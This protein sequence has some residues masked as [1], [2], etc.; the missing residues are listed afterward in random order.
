MGTMLRTAWCRRRA[1]AGCFGIL[2]AEYAGDV[3]VFVCVQKMKNHAFMGITLCLKNLFGLTVQEPYGRARQY[4]HHIIRMPYL[5]ADLGQIID[6]ALCIVDLAWSGYRG[7]NG[8]GSLARR[9][10]C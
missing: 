5:L 10:R 2:I 7:V 8:V 1:A 9:T 6:P 3:D 4:Y